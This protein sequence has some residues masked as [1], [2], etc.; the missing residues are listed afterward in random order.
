VFS[1]D[2]TFTDA[3]LYEGGVSSSPFDSEGSVCYNKELIKDGVVENFIYDIQTASMINDKTTANARRGYS[4]VPNPGFYNLIVKCGNT[5]YDHML[6][7][8]KE[9]ILVDEYIGGGQ[10]NV[11][12]GEF[13]V[14]LTL[15][16]KIENGVITKSIKD[17]MLSGNVYEIFKNSPV[18]SD[19]LH[20]RSSFYI[21]YL[22]ADNLSLTS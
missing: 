5:S 17:T 11:M 13:N 20:Q 19:E 22:L 7:G 2:F 21:P 8:I 15:A 9:G 18:F 10:S 6:S 1:K 12:A 3:P 16:F 4:S 14:N